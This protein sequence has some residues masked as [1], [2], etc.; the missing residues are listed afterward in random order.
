LVKLEK[1]D[2]A[3]LHCASAN[4]SFNSSPNSLLDALTG[5]ITV[6]SLPHVYPIPEFSN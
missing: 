6:P 4:S 2:H 1:Y 3:R 5:S